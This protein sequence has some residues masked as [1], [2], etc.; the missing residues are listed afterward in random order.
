MGKRS[1]GGLSTLLWIYLVCGRWQLSDSL[2]G[3]GRALLALKGKV[4]VDPYGA[5]ANWDEE[6]DDPCS[7]CGVECTDDGRVVVLNL[8]NLCLK[9]TLSPEVGKLIHLNTL[10]LHNNSFYGAVPGV[11]G[12]L[13]MLKVLDLGHNNFSGVLPSDLGDVA[14]LETL[15]LRGNRFA[16]DL[17][18]VW[19]K[20]KMLS[21]VQ[22]DKELL[23]SKRQFITMSGDVVGAI[24]RGL[25]GVEFKQND[26][27]HDN[28]NPGAPDPPANLNSR[29]PRSPS[30]PPPPH[31]PSPLP[32]PPPPPPPP[33][34]PPS[35]LPPP[36][37]PPPHPP[38][39]LPPPPP[40]PPPPPQSHPISSSSSL[41]ISLS[42]G[43]VVCF[44]I[45][46]SVI[47]LYH[48][49]TKKVVSVMPLMTVL[50][51]QSQK[52]LVTGV[53]ALRRLELETACEDFSNIIG[54]LSNCNLYKGTLSSG[55]EIAVTSAIVTSAKDWSV[56]DEAHFR[57]KISD[58]SKVNH[59]NF[60][61]LLGHCEEEAPFTRMMVFEYAP[62]GTLFEHLHIKEA[63]PLNWTARLRIAM[64]LAYCLEHMMQ[65][66]PPLIPRNLNSSSIYLTEDNAAK[67]SDLE[68]WNVET[69]ADMASSEITKESSIVYKFGIILLE[70]VS[71]RL[72]YSEDDGLLVLWARSYLSGKRPIKDMV[73][74]T[75]DPV[76][77]EDIN[78]LVEVIQSCI[79][80]DPNER[81]TM[82]EVADR[83]MLITAIP[84]EEANPKVSPLWWAELQII[85]SEAT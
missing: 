45:V 25:L 60:M 18:S 24:T 67:I 52:P 84:P 10:I 83:M 3:E 80:E 61:N 35:P 32:P 81:P 78:A 15:V 49:Q 28:K 77:D 72:P 2:N 63:E 71:G 5:L 57:K 21:E 59:K 44:L 11:I 1:L 38:S 41:I 64:G 48:K 8:K 66:N 30:A 75:L 58:L 22:V 6:D 34:H 7:W 79:D 82:K 39:P 27:A 85:S 20:F 69:E 51:G 50:N 9:G 68:F 43:G 37:P 36:P 76:P 65:L 56:Q 29:P 12:E 33:P 46:L 55:V 47:Y 17:L 53:P 13:Q 54:S 73:D 19:S 70:I 23:P 62:S 16:G 31:P 74:A 4:E 26:D 40:P 42:V 14:S